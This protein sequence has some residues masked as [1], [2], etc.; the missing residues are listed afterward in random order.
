MDMKTI[1]Y[2]YHQ[3]LPVDLS[4]WIFFGWCDKESYDEIKEFNWTTIYIKWD[5]VMMENYKA[6]MVQDV[7]NVNL[8]KSRIKYLES[9]WFHIEQIEDTT[10]YLGFG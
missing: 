7:H 2:R 8:Y 6:N 1:Y 9:I 4:K 5:N 3:H 10:K